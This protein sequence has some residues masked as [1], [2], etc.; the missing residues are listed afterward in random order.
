M[1]YRV[2]SALDEIAKAHGV[3]KTKTIDDA[4]MAAAGLPEPQ[5]DHAGAAE[6]MVLEMRAAL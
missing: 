6:S 3:A 2:F 5:T 4:Y 1:L